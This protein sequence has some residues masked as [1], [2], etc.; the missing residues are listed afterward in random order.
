MSA[1]LA[2]FCAGHK[3]GCRGANS[4][5]SDSH[6]MLPPQTS[7]SKASKSISLTR[8]KTS[9]FELVQSILV[10]IAHA[11]IYIARGSQASVRI[12]RIRASNGKLTISLFI[13]HFRQKKC[14][15][16]SQYDF[17]CTQEKTREFINC[18]LNYCLY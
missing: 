9:P 12:C 14:D 10:C 4:T 7:S 11:L 15:N 2:K 6:D 1:S 13:A 17:K 18:E 3:K 5:I 8:S 16:L